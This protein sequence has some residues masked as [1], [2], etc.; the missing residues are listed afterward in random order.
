[1]YMQVIAQLLMKVSNMII[2]T[3]VHLNYLAKASNYPMY[4][5]IAKLGKKR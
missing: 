2:G 4:T 5:E 1:M 3:I